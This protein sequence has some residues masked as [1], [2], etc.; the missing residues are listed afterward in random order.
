[1]PPVVYLSIHGGHRANSA[2]RHSILNNDITEKYTAII[3]IP[4][5]VGP[6]NHQVES[7]HCII[8]DIQNG[9]SAQNNK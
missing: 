9:F 6:W 2:G 4:C 7:P 3:L 1:M 8:K 5:Q